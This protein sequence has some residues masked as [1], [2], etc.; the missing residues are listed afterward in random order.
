M[1]VHSR[2]HWH[3]PSLKQLIVIPERSLEWRY[4]FILRKITVKIKSG[5]F[6]YPFGLKKKKK[7]SNK[8]YILRMQDMFLPYLCLD[9]SLSLSPVC[10]LKQGTVHYE[11]TMNVYVGVC[12]CPYI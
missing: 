11:D 5:R 1:E 2:S 3:F 4:E 10:L 12:V 8:L 7:K 6:K 9:S